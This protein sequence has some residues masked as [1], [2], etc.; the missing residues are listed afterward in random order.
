MRFAR[1]PV[2][3]ATIAV[4]AW[5]GASA[6]QPRPRVDAQV[7]HASQPQL[8]AEALAKVKPTPSDRA[9][10]YFLGVAGYGGQAVFKR[11]VLSVRELFDQRFGTTDRSV[12]LI[13]HPST[14]RQFPLATI[15]NLEHVLQGLARL[16]D[17]DRDTLFFFLTS[18]GDRGELALQLPD[19]ALPQLKPIQ[20]KMMLDRSGIRNRVVVISACHSGSFIPVVADARTLVIT[21]ARGDRSSFGC[22]DRRRWTYFGNAFFNRALRQEMSFVGAFARAKRTIAQWEKAERLKPSLP[23]IAGGDAL[24]PALAALRVE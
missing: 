24:G 17:R 4:L 16:M 11:E 22:E 23:Q 3:L 18:H 9:Q 7:I 6:E 2:L 10:L 19:V 21:A 5:N 14:L 15:S 1:I 20:L 12:A 13:N 8:L